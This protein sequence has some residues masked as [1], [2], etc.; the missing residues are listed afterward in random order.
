MRVITYNICARSL[1]MQMYT[2]GFAPQLRLNSRVFAGVKNTCIGGDYF[3][4]DLTCQTSHMAVLNATLLQT[5]FE[6][7]SGQSIMSDSKFA[8]TIVCKGGLVY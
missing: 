3:D 4:K 8:E 6:N 7:F 2:N 1:S 5:E